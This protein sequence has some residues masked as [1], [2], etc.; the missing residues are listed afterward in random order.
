MDREDET[1]CWLGFGRG[2]AAEGV[3]QGR[4]SVVKEERTTTSKGHDTMIERDNGGRTDG[5]SLGS[6]ASRGA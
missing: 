2:E 6:R 1:D 3:M 4:M 5:R